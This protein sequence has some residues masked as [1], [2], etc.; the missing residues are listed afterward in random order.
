VLKEGFDP[1]YGARLGLVVFPLVP[2]VPHLQS[3]WRFHHFNGDL[4]DGK[5]PFLIGKSS[6]NRPIMM[7][8]SSKYQ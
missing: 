1:A 2:L 7:K 5:P 4:Y 3:C 8:T 6:I